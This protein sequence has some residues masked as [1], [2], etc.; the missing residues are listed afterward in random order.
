MK[1][2]KFSSMLIQFNNGVNAVSCSSNCVF[3]NV[4]IFIS[5]ETN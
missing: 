4:T 5:Y 1:L 3:V 2:V